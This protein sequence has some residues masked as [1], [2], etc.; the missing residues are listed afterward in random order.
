MKDYERSEAGFQDEGIQKRI[1]EKA[2]LDA[3]GE[4]EK[5][6][7]QADQ[8]A[9]IAAAVVSDLTSS[10]PGVLGFLA[11]TAAAVGGAVVGQKLQERFEAED[12]EIEVGD[13]HDQAGEASTKSLNMQVVTQ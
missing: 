4:K 11:S 1:D 13:E 10:L 12:E 6:R 7:T 9:E 5:P 2:A 8:C 3:K